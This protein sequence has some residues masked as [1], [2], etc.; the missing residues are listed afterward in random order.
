MTL[1]DRTPAW[2]RA[3]VVAIVL[4]GVFFRFYHLDRKVF[5]EDEILG[6]VHT[7]GYTE[8]EI[9]ENSNHLVDAGDVQAYFRPPDGLGLRKDSLMNTVDA[10]ALEDPQ[11]PPL[12]YLAG[13]LWAERFGSS[14]AAIRALSAIIGVLVLPCLFWLCLELFGSY[15]AAWTAVALTALSPFQVLYSQEAREY[16]LWTVAILLMSAAFLRACRLMTLSAWA[17]YC[18]LVALSMYVYPFSGLVALGEGVFLLSVPRL[19]ASGAFVSY[20]AA[21][22][23]AFASFLPWLVV[24]VRSSGLRR[25]MATILTH[26]VHVS[27]IAVTF[28][29][30][31]RAV[32]IDFGRVQIH[33]V[34]STEINGAFTAVVALL[35]AVSVYVMIRRTSWNVAGFVLLALC[36][37]SAPLLIHDV[38]FGGIL[39]DQSRYF[40]PVYLGAELAV[41]AFVYLNLFELPAGVLRRS[42]TWCLLAALL[43]GEGLSCA[44]SSRADTWWNKD[45][46]VS[47]SVAATIDGADRPLVVSDSYASRALGLAYYLDPRVALRLHL[48]C[49]Q[50]AGSAPAEDDLLADSSRFH[51]IFF[52]GASQRLLDRANL[53]GPANLRYYIDVAAFPPR[54]SPLGMFLSI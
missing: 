9:V 20:A 32:F 11:H 40:V 19:R 38:A 12:Y 3:A 41:V 37:P 54:P 31:L 36:L 25:G 44:L 5:W 43:F 7:L 4:L 29:K 2:F 33:H 52:L 24:M 39:V 10:L 8:A 46:E 34:S 27:T 45:Y 13:H 47:R 17:L 22:L 16:T 50:C 49:D 35:I 28:L 51:T 26:R 21:C 18:V 1:R 6:T 15:A 30:N 53:S 23:I 42:L 14:V 48:T